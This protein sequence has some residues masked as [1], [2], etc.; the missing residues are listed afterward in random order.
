MSYAIT[1]LELRLR[2]EVKYHCWSAGG[3]SSTPLGLIQTPAT[4][5][6][7]KSQ[8]RPSENR[9]WMEWLTIL[10]AG[11][12]DEAGRSRLCSTES[13]CLSIFML[14]STL[15]SVKACH[16]TMLFG[17]FA[18]V[19]VHYNCRQWGVH[20]F[21]ALFWYVCSISCFVPCHTCSVVSVYI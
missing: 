11:C 18:C 5:L 16:Y 7:R 2:T 10:A 20:V 9:L 14:F 8:C 15:K 21:P 12:L 1:A 19:W 3:G 17:F 4:S 13:A 6:S